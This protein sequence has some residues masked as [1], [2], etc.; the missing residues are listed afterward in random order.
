MQNLIDYSLSLMPTC[1]YRRGTA[2]R[3]VSVELF[4]D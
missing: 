3:A 4:V 1:F 2:R